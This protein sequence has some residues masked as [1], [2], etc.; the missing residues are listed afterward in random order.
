MR[1][2][3][4]N[5]YSSAYKPVFKSSDY[6]FHDNETGEVINRS[7]TNFFR[8]DLQCDKLTN[9]L[10]KNYNDTNNVN[11]YCFGCSD[12]SEP[13]S[14]AISL[15]EKLGEVKAQKFFPIKAFDINEKI[16]HSAKSGFIKMDFWDE[17]EIN[18]HTNNNLQK[19]FG[20]QK[21]IRGA[22]PYIPDIIREVKPILRNAVA[23]N[24]GDI[25]EKINIIEKENSVILC[26]NFWPYI[27][28]YSEKI[29]VFMKLNKQIGSNSF[30]IIGQFDKE[31]DPAKKRKFIDTSYLIEYQGFNKVDNYAYKKDSLPDLIINNYPLHKIKDDF[32]YDD[33]A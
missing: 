4:I 33:F 31:G 6:E 17:E 25:K 27:E 14:I 12:G 2:N 28:N 9:F 3:S 30:L 10:I 5:Y 21:F 19:Y 23:F 20:P 1:I 18:K 22:D 15:I 24:L 29:D 32:I 26:R 11:I 13:Y 8:K 7:T 16:I